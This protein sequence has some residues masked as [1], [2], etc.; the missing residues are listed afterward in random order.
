MYKPKGGRKPTFSWVPAPDGQVRPALEL[1]NY[2]ASIQKFFRKV[3]RMN[4]GEVLTPYVDELAALRELA[5][6]N[7][8]RVLGPQWFASLIHLN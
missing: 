8:I 4:G 2:C 7:G 1:F 3:E 6:E 5:R